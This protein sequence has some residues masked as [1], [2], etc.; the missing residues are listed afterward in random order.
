MLSELSSYYS[1][2]HLQLGPNANYIIWSVIISVLYFIYYKKFRIYVYHQTPGT[3]FP[4]RTDSKFLPGFPFGWYRLF[5]SDELK[6]GQVK[7]KKCLGEN[8]VVFRGTDKKVYVLDAYCLHMG[9][10][11]AIGGKVKNTSCIECPFHGWLYDGETGN[12]LSGNGKEAKIADVYEYHDI[13]KLTMKDGCYFRKVGTEEVK[14]RKWV[15]NETH[16]QIFMWYHPDEIHREKPLFELFD[17]SKSFKHLEYRGYGLNVLQNHIHEILENT[18][19]YLHFHYVH[20]QL[21]N[22]SDF[23]RFVWHMRWKMAGDVDLEE[24]MACSDPKQDK[25]RKD[26]LREF[27]NDK[28]KEY[29]SINGLDNRFTIPPLGFNT[30]FLT[31]TAI[32]LGPS[33]V[34]FF[35]RSP[36]YDV[37]LSITCLPVEKYQQNFVV[38]LF[39]NKNLPYWLTAQVIYFEIGQISNDAVVWDQ[40]KNP[41]KIYYNQFGPFDKIFIDWRNFYGKFFVESGAKELKRKEEEEKRK[42]IEW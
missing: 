2:L 41:E 18:G 20:G 5:D 22:N 37:L 6:P 38:T 35:F 40:K 4:N 33:V 12:C 17:I 36:I 21:I 32:H 7:H 34:Y 25:I 11:L 19:D 1:S 8:L 27:I 29:I 15:V 9:A 26:L 24:Y 23:I 28:N 39:T 42:K 30:H 3:K 31:G 16:H 10:N 13:E 14:L